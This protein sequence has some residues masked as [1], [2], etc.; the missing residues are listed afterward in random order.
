MLVCSRQADRRGLNEGPKMYCGEAHH[1]TVDLSRQKYQEIYRIH[2]CNKL[3]TA[4]NT[5]VLALEWLN[6][7]ERTYV[8]WARYDILHTQND[9]YP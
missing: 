6:Q 9:I 4:G 3:R 1:G 8:Y 5:M 2:G 7:T